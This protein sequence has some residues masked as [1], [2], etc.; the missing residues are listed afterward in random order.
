VGATPVTSAALHGAGRGETVLLVEDEDALR[1]IAREMLEEAGYRVLTA[2][3][4]GDGLRVLQSNEHID[5]LVSDVGLPGGM[6]GRQMAD[7][8]RVSR[9]E[10]KVLFITGYADVSAIGANGLLD[11]GMALMSKPFDLGDLIRRVREMI[12]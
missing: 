11:K 2:A 4:A 3:N 5:L 6:N 1:D 10:L 12:G 9:P 7:V 8:G